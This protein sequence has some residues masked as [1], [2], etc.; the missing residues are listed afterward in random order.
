MSVS[1][2]L[3][4]NFTPEP[5]PASVQQGEADGLGEGGDSFAGLLASQNLGDLQASLVDDAAGVED[6]SLAGDGKGLPELIELSA[7]DALLGQGSLVTI[8]A[9][10]AADNL[11]EGAQQWLQWLDEARSSLETPD[12]SDGPEA[13]PLT[14]PDTLGLAPDIRSA[15]VDSR[16]GLLAPLEAGKGKTDIAQ[17]PGELGARDAAASRAQGNDLQAHTA[18]LQRAASVALAAETQAVVAQRMQDPE[19]LLP[20]QTGAE[21]EALDGRSGSSQSLAAQAAL[22]ARPVAAPAQA[23]G[24]PFNQSGW[25][26][27]M[28]EKV[29]WMSS[30][31]LR[32]VEIR[33]DPEELGPL[34]IRIQNRGQEN[35][36]QFLS[37]N[38]SVREALES[39]M[40]RLRELFSQQGMDR[41]D[42]TV[43]DNSPRDASGGQAHAGSGERGGQSSRA[44]GAP[45]AEPEQSIMTT[46]AAAR[47][48]SDRLVDYYA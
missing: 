38:P 17:S 23:L 31:T 22:T 12:A 11:A 48:S 30:Q 45:R 19:A 6:L 13:V 36:I 35:Q 40:F 34:E 9:D 15:A 28:V 14:R 24:V 5:R 18:P 3:L 37:Q 41:V 43:A 46:S 42:V 10:Q 7:E 47:V 29:M 39:Q 20:R 32:S 27:A 21:A 33:L 2:M 4:A 25:G 26:E 1:Q 44:E 16:E 8:E